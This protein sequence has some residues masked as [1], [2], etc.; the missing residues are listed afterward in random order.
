[1]IKKEKKPRSLVFKIA[2]WSSI[3]LLVIL[4]AFVSIPFLFKDKIVEIVSKSINKNINATVT[5]KE[6]NLSF[7]K[8]FPLASL[9]VN[10]VV[11]ANKAPFLGDTLFSTK[12]LSMS[13]KITELFKSSEEAIELKSFSSKN[14]QIN[15]I[16][17]TDDLG[18]YDVAL[19][20]DTADANEP[21]SFSL[22]IQDYQFEN[23][24]FMYL[25]RSSNMK[26]QLDSI[27]HYGKGNFAK[28]ILDLDTKTTAK[29][30]FDYENTNFFNNVN[31]SLNAILGIDL[32]NSKFTFKE[33][34]G[35]IN[36]LAL[37]FDGFIQ[38]VDETQLYDINFKT[39]TSDFKNLLALLPKQ[40][41]GDLN[42]IKT[43]GNFDLNGVIKGV[44]SDDRIPAF[45]ISF[46][47]KNAMFKYDD[48][49]K[50]VQ[51]I[52][53]DSRIINKTGIVK[54]TYINLNQLTFKI[55]KDVFAANGTIADIT[56]NAK[57][58][59][60]AKGTIN[61]AN[62]GKVYP[63]PIQQ[64]LA[65][66]LNA[67]ITTNFD[68]NSVEKGNY[69]NIKNAGQLKVT[70]FKYNGKDVA[71]PF[72]IKKTAITFNT[73]TITLNEFD[74]KTGDSDIS[75]TG[76]LENFYGFIFKDQELKGNF[77]LNSNNFKVSDFLAADATTDKKE[78][79]SS[80]K[81][82][83]F[84]DCKFNATANTVVY[85][86]INLK[87]VSGTIYIKDEAVNLQNLKTD[88]FGGNIGF[89]G[90]VST[91][92]K[93]SSFSMDLNLKELNIAE[94]FGTLDMLKAIA[95]I[96]KTIEGKMNSTINVAGNL[97][98]DFTPDLKT[99]TGN[100]LGQ[101]LS[102]KINASNSKALSLLG[103]KVAFLDVNK[104]NLDKI[105]GY[106]AFEN[107]VVTVKPIPLKYQ[108]IGIEIGGKHGFDNTM[109]YDIKFDVPVK[110][111]GTEVTNLIA[112]LSPKDAEKITTLPVRAN[113]N[114]SF[115]SPSFSTNIKDATASFIKNLVEQQKQSLVNSGKDKLLNLIG[116]DTTKDS[117]KTKD[118]LINILTGDKKD[119]T[120][121]TKEDKV[122]DAIN[123]LF[124]KKKNN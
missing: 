24:R 92:G 2:K 18:N 88:V 67:D 104:I 27:Y 99:I 63:A 23:M 111:L 113:L 90:K 93:T 13:M 57:I 32:K 31:V 107:G 10:N 37:A 69:E 119:S 16:F 60:A 49:P 68:M 102:T 124:K 33:N 110:Y 15:I 44:L 108:D 30:S 46:A 112:K 79:T 50:S 54:D 114:G 4:L 8:N 20:K 123:G 55:D 5:F 98:D 83:A 91:K 74:A 59:L 52:Y 6:T 70:D 48:L 34:T 76:N 95:P 100:L 3:T 66:I 120:K 11:V 77:N 12:E 109:N 86:N 101:L 117:T 53:I 71:K 96:A 1:M 28:E 35:Y 85:D 47:S 84:L 43:E 40:Y 14:G 9:T 82:P 105:T 38:L 61:L 87:N 115:S 21:A 78:E 22:N 122:K 7:F 118:K 75:I 65:G 58:N 45:D 72:Y 81:I 64:E 121:T 25:D 73:N 29:L 116:G 97:N 106:F 89:T 42:A 103:D 41:S 62:I 26:M 80:I 94:S 56:T 36:Q 19:K 39:P 51:N 17:N